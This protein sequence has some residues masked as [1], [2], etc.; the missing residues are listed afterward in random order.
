MTA[1]I[2]QHNII[3]YGVNRL[4]DGR[5]DGQTDIDDG[6]RPRFAPRMRGLKIL[7]VHQFECIF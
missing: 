4:C 1:P 7:K 2:G 6:N 5:T 3:I